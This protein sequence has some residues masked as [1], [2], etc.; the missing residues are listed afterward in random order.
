L[1]PHSV[2]RGACFFPAKEESINSWKINGGL[3]R[4]LMRNASNN[5]HL[6]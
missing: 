5:I 2:S 3:W 1:T 6:I 4:N